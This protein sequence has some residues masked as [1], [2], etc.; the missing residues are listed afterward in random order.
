MKVCVMMH[1]CTRKLCTC[2][3]S[4]EVFCV[5]HPSRAWQLLLPGR[6]TLKNMD[7]VTRSTVAVRLERAAQLQK[8]TRFVLVS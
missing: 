2:S 5:H 4:G 8:E 7:D 1:A 3:A 6:E